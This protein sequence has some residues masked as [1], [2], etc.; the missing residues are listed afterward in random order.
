VGDSP[1]FSALNAASAP[2]DRVGSALTIANCIGFAIT[3]FSIQL[4]NLLAAHWPL[5]YLLVLLAPG[6][7]LGLLA[8]RPLLRRT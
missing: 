5:Q 7:I 8:L 4:L 2:P 3:I 6:P 1:Q